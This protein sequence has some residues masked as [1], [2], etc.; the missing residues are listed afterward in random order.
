MRDFECSKCNKGISYTKVI[1]NGSGLCNE[2]KNKKE[3][4]EKLKNKKAIMRCKDKKNNLKLG[5]ILN[6][7]KEKSNYVI[8]NKN[9]NEY[10]I[11]KDKV[12]IIENNENL[13]LVAEVL[14]KIDKHFDDIS[15]KEFEE[16]LVKAKGKS[17]K[18]NIV[19]WMKTREGETP[20]YFIFGIYSEE[21]DDW[22]KTNLGYFKDLSKAKEIVL[23]NKTNIHE[24]IHDYVVISEKEEWGL[25]PATYKEYW[26]KFCEKE[27]KYD[28][29]PKPSFLKGFSF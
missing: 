27:K 21:D 10:C 25:Y 9:N 22:N 12:S 14:R 18:R 7:S 23:N 15:N 1:N 26:Y 3:R 8:A 13:E 17:I 20:M 16:K 24:T 4:K 11:S 28:P 19:E 6:I 5:E 2:C 29:C